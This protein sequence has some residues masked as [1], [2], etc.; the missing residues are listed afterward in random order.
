MENISELL[1]S[2]D[3]E[4]QLKLEDIP[5]I[6]LYMDQVI[7]LFENK[8]ASVKRN[9][10]DKIL[11]KTMINNYAKGKLFFPITNKKYSP[12]HIILISFIYNF[13]GAL[14]INDI[15]QVLHRLNE[16]ITNDNYPVEHLY[17]QYLELSEID[18]NKFKADVLASKENVRHK[19]EEM[20][21][22]D[23]N[24]V[25]RL[26]LIASFTTMSNFYRRAAE[27]LVDGI[28]NETK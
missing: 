24:Y 6:D 7:Q 9:E 26:L 21:E 12:E 2:L 11:T 5:D 18:M 1:R 8:Y 25:E 14:S 22:A 27:K 19:V 28:V 10:D 4:K 17:K 15:K 13:K 20:N 3:L 16:K 23:A